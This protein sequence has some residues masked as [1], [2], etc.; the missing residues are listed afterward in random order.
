MLPLAQPPQGNDPALTRWLFL[1]WKRINSAAGMAW[2]LIDKTSS[3]L[4]DI[5]TRNHNDLQT[6]QGGTANEYYHLTGAQNTALTIWAGIT[7]ES[8]E[9][10]GVAASLILAHEGLTTSMSLEAGEN[11]T[12]G[13]PLYV[14]ANKFYVA[15]NIANF[16]VVAIAAATT[17]LG[18]ICEGRTFGSVVLSGLSVGTPY[19]L[20]NLVI[21]NTPPVAGYVV[22]VGQAIRSDL[23][24]VNIEDS[25]LLS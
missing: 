24:L 18:L 9:D 23:L 15:D 13:D 14:S 4:T 19:F 3:N 1:L 2:G 25:I 10:T 20:G 8:K 7:P 16:R 5:E 22:R 12:I 11:I 21:Q 6:I 17:T